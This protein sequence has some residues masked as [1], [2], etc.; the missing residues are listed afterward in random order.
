M[1][2]ISKNQIIKVAQSFSQEQFARNSVIYT[3]GQSSE[4][5]YIVQ[6]GEFEISRKK[7]TN[8]DKQILESVARSFI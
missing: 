4:Y 8:N 3:Q 2:F 6:N 7:K 1:K 5:V